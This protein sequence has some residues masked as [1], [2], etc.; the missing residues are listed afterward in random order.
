MSIFLSALFLDPLTEWM[1]DDWQMIGSLM[2]GW[3][4][5]VN[6]SRTGKEWERT[7]DISWLDGL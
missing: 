2:G 3:L 1:D 7:I 4:R 5:L 6:T